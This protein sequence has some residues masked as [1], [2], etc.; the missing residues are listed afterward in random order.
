MRTFSLLCLVSLV[1]VT[2]LAEPV[3]AGRRGRRRA[4]V[5]VGIVA[6]TARPAAVVTP[7]VVAAPA[8]VRPAY[9]V[10]TPDLTVTEISVEGD[11]H[12]ISVKN[13]G[14]VASPETQLQIDFLRLEDGVFLA[15]EK[16]RVM[17]LQVNQSLRFRLHALP[18]G[19]VEVVAEVDPNHRVAEINEQNN[20]LRLGIAPEPPA[21]E[22]VAL[23]DVE[24]WIV[25]EAPL[26][27]R[28]GG[29]A[30]NDRKE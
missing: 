1:A 7:R 3:E 11:L 27:D 10:L 24:V 13:I 19:H 22:P 17:P 2:S 9:V 26:E 16:V 25:P 12:C 18:G 21:A 28:E 8:V 20:E 30:I 5:A 6:A 29:P 4:A 14:Q 15:T 23:R